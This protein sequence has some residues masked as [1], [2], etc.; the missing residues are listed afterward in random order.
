VHVC[1]NVAPVDIK[2][3]IG[4]IVSRKSND[5]LLTTTYELVVRKN[6]IA[7]ATY[8]KESWMSP[9]SENDSFV[10][11]LSSQH[12]ATSGDIDGVADMIRPFSK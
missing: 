7:R 12:N 6:E 4:K 5:W 3:I 9:F 1:G 8:S 2:C 11:S 10:L